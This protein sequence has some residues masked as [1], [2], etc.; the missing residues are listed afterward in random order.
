MNIT[1][2]LPTSI[3]KL[4]RGEYSAPGDWADLVDLGRDYY[5]DGKAGRAYVSPEAPE[6]SPRI[7]AAADRFL[8]ACWEQGRRDA[9]MLGALEE[10]D[11][12]EQ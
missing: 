5:R 9:G 6:F 4:L 12:D 2:P 3:V 10:T 1:R 7:V 11:H 8:S